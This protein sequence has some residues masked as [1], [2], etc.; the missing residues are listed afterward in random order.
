[1]PG[2]VSWSGARVSG[3][4]PGPSGLRLGGVRKVFWCFSG[5]NLVN[6]TARNLSHTMPQPYIARN[7]ATPMTS[8]DSIA[9]PHRPSPRLYRRRRLHRTN[10]SPRLHRHDYIAATLPRPDP[11]P[12]RP[13]GARHDVQVYVSPVRDSFHRL[14]IAERPGRSGSPS[15]RIARPA[16]A[17]RY[18]CPPA[19]GSKA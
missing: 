3:S 18:R 15:Q 10:S 19:E 12:L 6:A 9:R 11:K 2:A 5:G 13:E 1:M 17:S 16:I 4:W 14:H 8:Y 7:F